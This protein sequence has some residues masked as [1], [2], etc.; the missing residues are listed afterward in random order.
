[1]NNEET[2]K[3]ELKELMTDIPSSTIP[4]SKPDIPITEIPIDI[5][6]YNQLMWENK[7]NRLLTD[8]KYGENLARYGENKISN[9][10]FF[11]R[12]ANSFCAI[13]SNE[14]QKRGVGSESLK[15]HY[16]ILE[17]CLSLI[18]KE[19]DKN[20]LKDQEPYA[21]ISALHG[22]ITNYNQKKRN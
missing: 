11:D 13:I 6:V 16:A 14:F 4:L 12:F 7:S 21:I 2:L 17:S 3:N 10:A 1:M 18:A 15:P 9:K 19:I 8:Y 22:F 5:N 20:E